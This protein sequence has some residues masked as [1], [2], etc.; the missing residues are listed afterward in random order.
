MTD[1]QRE[2]ARTLEQL[3]ARYARTGR[4]TLGS[5]R[6]FRVVDRGRRVL[7]CRSASGEDAVQCLWS[8]SIDDGTEQLLVD[9]ATLTIDDADLPPAERA[10]RERAR[11][12]AAGIVAYSVDAAARRC[13]FALG[14]ELFVA[15]LTDGTVTS[16]VTDGVV[17]DP[18]LSDDGSAVAYSSAGSLRLCVLDPQESAPVDRELRADPDPL[19][20]FGRAEFVAAEEMGRSRG[21]W[22]APDSSCL[23]VT[24]VD[25]REVAELWIADPAHPGRP[26][27]SVRYPAAGTVNASV[28]LELVDRDGAHRAVDWSDGGRFE[29]LADVIWRSGHNPLVVRQTRDQRTVSIAEVTVDTAARSNDGQREDGS[30]ITAKTIHDGAALAVVERWTITDDIWVELMPG[31]PVWSA[32][33]LLTIEDRGDV[34][35]LLLAGQPVGPDRVNIRSVVG[36]V[37]VPTT[38]GEPSAA[39][40]PDG[41]AES[42]DGSTTE[43][44]VVTAWTDPTE[45][46]VLAIPLGTE[47]TGAAG[48]AVALTTE[49][50]VHTAAVGGAT[51]AITSARPDRA[52]TETTVHRLTAGGLQG[53]RGH[54][55]ADHAADPG[56]DA[57]PAFAVLG[58]SELPAAVFL[59]SDHDGSTPLPVLLDPYGGPHAQRVLRHHNGH[60]PSRWFAEHGYAV[61]VA[62]GRGTP[63][64][65]PAWE[66]AVWG[67]LAAPALADQI[68]ALDAALDT[69]DG[70]DG[71]RVAIRGWSFGGYLAAL[72]VLRRPDRFHAAIAGAPVT[73]WGLYDTHYTERYLGHPDEHP[74]HYDRSDLWVDGVAGPQI[75]QLQ[76]PM[77][78]IHG[79]ADDNVVAAHTLRFSTALLATGSPHRVLPLSGVTHMTPQV[80]VAE[81]LLRLQL[82]FL[83][84]TIRGTAAP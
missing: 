66:R 70:L 53:E 3:P 80:A 16:P 11:E 1:R 23:L 83:D 62:D 47:A 18:H 9:P 15:D 8:L 71:S 42:A 60:I 68:E 76:R 25:D 35:Q 27:T 33:G 65:G 13:C 50:G 59:P 2:T 28:A 73:R 78:L 26:P 55:I 45:I 21:F 31:S 14:G 64:R 22:W 67:D 41:S 75:E 44:A 19:I 38:P 17:F 72:A 57:A 52:G 4:F 84:E 43:L 37:T 82:D 36:V 29:Y 20:S 54:V 63:G 48:A 46:H 58:R 74:E 79:L 12:S 61:V 69:F 30:A 34:R 5:P 51:I 39:D 56:L 81:N 32:S 6:T 40:E 10:R 7:F 24:R 49:P 77:L